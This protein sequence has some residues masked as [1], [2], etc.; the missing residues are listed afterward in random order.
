MTMLENW[1]LLKFRDAS[2]S[3]VQLMRL[4]LGLMFVSHVG[5]CVWAAVG[6][7]QTRSIVDANHAADNSSGLPL[8]DTS[9]LLHESLM[10]PVY[11]L[12]PPPSPRGG[13][14]AST[15]AS[16]EPWRAEQMLPS[17]DDN[18]MLEHNAV[19]SWLR[20]FYFTLATITVVVIGDITPTTLT[21]TIGCIM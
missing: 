16:F 18:E 1:V 17:G 15:C 6:W 4:L 12:S 13:E 8:T 9:W 11:A 2:P 19:L 10:Q 20:G 21:E 3:Q 7:S 5:A 14:N